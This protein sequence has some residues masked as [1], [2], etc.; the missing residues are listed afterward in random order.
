[1]VRRSD[2]LTVGRSDSC[3]ER[4]ILYD[5]RGISLMRRPLYVSILFSGCQTGSQADIFAGDRG[6]M[7]LPGEVSSCNR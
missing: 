2:G 5:G 1:M 7:R 6:A 3:K 4:R